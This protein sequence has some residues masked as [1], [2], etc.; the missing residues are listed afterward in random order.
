VVEDRVDGIARLE[1]FTQLGNR[2]SLRGIID[3]SHGG[4]LSVRSAGHPPIISIMH[5]AL[6][7]STIDTSRMRDQAE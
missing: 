6:M 1:H 7:M 4:S 2:L 3:P 5:S